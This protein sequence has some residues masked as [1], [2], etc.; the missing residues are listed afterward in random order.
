MLCGRETWKHKMNLLDIVLSDFSQEDM[1]CTPVLSLQLSHL[2]SL[3][4]PLPQ[5]SN[6]FSQLLQSLLLSPVL[7][8]VEWL[9]CCMLNNFLLTAVNAVDLTQCWMKA[10]IKTQIL[11]R[12]FMLGLSL[13]CIVTD[14]RASAHLRAYLGEFSPHQQANWMQKMFLLTASYDP[15]TS[16]NDQDRDSFVCVR[17]TWECIDYRLYIIHY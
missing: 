17:T 10:K 3:W 9:C 5:H 16:R 12:N 15:S 14:D 6:P 1:I 11:L 13:L 2:Q 7:A 8:R 4:L